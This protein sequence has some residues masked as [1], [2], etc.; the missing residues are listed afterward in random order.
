MGRLYELKFSKIILVIKKFPL[1]KE[2]EL[3]FLL[4]QEQLNINT[5]K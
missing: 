4:I 5:C 2:W 3:S 1:S